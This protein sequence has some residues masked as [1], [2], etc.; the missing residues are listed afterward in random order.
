MEP[1]FWHQRWQSNKIGFH[2]GET[3]A[4]LAKHFGKLLLEKNARLFI[5]LCGKTRDIAWLL[6][7]GYRVAGIELSEQA[8]DQL[9]SE[10]GVQPDIETVGNLQHYSHHHIDIFAGDIFDLSVEILGQ[11]DAVY[12]RAAL[13]ALPPQMRTQYSEHLTSITNTASQFL[14]C[15]EYDQSQMNGPP[16]SINALEVKLQYTHAY[17]ITLIETVNV[18]HGL[19]KLMPAKETVWLLR[20]KFN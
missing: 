15:F 13:V 17:G 8:V 19:R 9:F 5:P 7:Q 6:S 11:V 2:E 18:T 10:L 4:L 3:N 14:I 12:D 1:D 16:F 20:K